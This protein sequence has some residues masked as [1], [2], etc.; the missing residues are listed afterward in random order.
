[1]RNGDENGC[2][3]SRPVSI[4]KQA[5]R[6]REPDLRRQ[7]K[8]DL[9]SGE[10]RRPLGRLTG[11][12]I[13]E[14]QDR[15]PAEDA[16][17]N[18]NQ[19][20]HARRPFLLAIFCKMIS[21]V[22]VPFFQKYFRSKTQQQHYFAHDDLQRVLFPEIVCT[23]VFAHRQTS[24]ICRRRSGANRLR[25]KVRANVPRSSQD[26]RDIPPGEPFGILFQYT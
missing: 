7:P 14:E 18:D 1:M 21:F 26:L 12:M 23:T 19:K 20:R 4:S 17:H 2:R 24:P 16:G 3:R 25:E 15:R 11:D 6:H 13:Y 8:P 22:G 5:L 10:S 9:L